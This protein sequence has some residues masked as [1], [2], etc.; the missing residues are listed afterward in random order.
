[1]V[2]KSTPEN[3]ASVNSDLV[4]VYYDANAIDPTKLNYKY[5]GE[6]WIEGVKVYT[7][8]VYPRPAGAFGVF[9]FSA[10]IRNRLTPLFTPLAGI[11][12]HKEQGTG[13]WQLSVHVRVR[14]EYN[15]T[16]GAVVLIDA[17]KYFYNHYQGRTSLASIIS[18]LRDSPLTTRDR[19][20]NLNFTDNFYVPY[21]S[22][23]NTPFTVT[24]GA[25]V[26]TITPAASPSLYS[27]DISP[28][29]INADFPGAI[30][31]SDTSYTVTFGGQT[32]KVNILCP[33]LYKNYT[34]HFLNQFGGLESFLFNKPSKTTYDY[35]KKEYRQLPYR[36]HSIYGVVT[37]LDGV[38]MNE[39]RTV[40]AS[41]IS[42]KLKLQTD[43]V[44]DTDYKF[45]AQLVASPLVMIGE[46]GILYPV[47][48]S[49]TNYEVKQY[50]TDKLTTLSINVEF[51]TQQ[52]QY[53]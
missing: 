53:R 21:F 17:S 25:N 23:I 51:P 10:Q 30:L 1:M 8:R 20:V 28:A 29:G 19:T 50:L 13:Q 18:P 52:T 47:I 16:V 35:E 33:G 38:Q 3:F 7:E 39:Q 22:L 32:F 34:V 5:V 45:L 41:Q 26:K 24:V 15:G 2:N 11:E 6:L 46:G 43:F 37:L 12:G 9:N 44:S 27:L 14:E 36:I 42:E 48:I 31:P 4:F 40:F 49:D